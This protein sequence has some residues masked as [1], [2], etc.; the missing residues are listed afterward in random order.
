MF[1]L[2]KIE[3]AMVAFRAMCRQILAEALHRLAL[4]HRAIGLQI[5][6][7]TNVQP[8]T[9]YYGGSLKT[10]DATQTGCQREATRNERTT[11]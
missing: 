10:E 2:N 11:W 3:R 5:E 9:T 6:R 1:V 7:L 4:A 8:V